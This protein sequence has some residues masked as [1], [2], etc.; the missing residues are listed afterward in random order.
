MDYPQH[1]AGYG[2]SMSNDNAFKAREN[3]ARRAVARQGYKLI[4]NRVRDPRVPTY[5]QYMIADPYT[6]GIVAG[7]GGMDWN[8]DLDDVEKWLGGELT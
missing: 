6:N 2:S 1:H 7:S 3:K 8:L 5:G 4:K